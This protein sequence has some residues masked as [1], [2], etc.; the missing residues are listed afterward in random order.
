SGTGYIISPLVRIG[1]LWRRCATA[2][3]NSLSLNFGLASIREN[4]RQ[5]N[6]S[7]LPVTE[8][9]WEFSTLEPCW[10][11]R[12]AFCCSRLRHGLNYAQPLTDRADRYARSRYRAGHGVLSRQ[13][14]DAVSLRRPGQDGVLRLWR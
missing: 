3:L 5:D 6:F 13:A 10:L 7:H 1:S 2:K 14:R 11:L 4:E 12:F 9:L 8:F